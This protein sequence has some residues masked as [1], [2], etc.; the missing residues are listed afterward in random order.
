MLYEVITLPVV[1]II[2][3]GTSGYSANASNTDDAEAKVTIQQEALIG[4]AVAGTPDAP[5]TVAASMGSGGNFVVGAN[6]NGGGPGVPLSI[7]SKGSVTVGSS[8]ST[9]SLQQFSEDQCQSNTYSDNKSGAGSDILQN[10]SGFPANL[11]AYLFGFTT[12]DQILTVINQLGHEKMNPSEC[13]N[14]DASSRGMYLVEGPGSCNL[15]PT[16]NIIGSEEH[17]VV[18]ILWNAVITSY[19][20][21]Y[22]KLYDAVAP[23]ATSSDIVQPGHI[24]PLMAQDGGVLTR[25][26]HTEAGCDLGRLAGLEPAAVIVEILNRITSY[27]VCYTKLLRT[28]LSNIASSLIR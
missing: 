9:C 26:G 28:I 11:M 5:L 3:K 20:I 6:P 10:D 19:S 27:N 4:R 18:I 2:A 23:N 8:S 13:G 16:G 14:F 7:W 21:H 1:N 12:E 22:T 24:F 17:P 15:N 25:N